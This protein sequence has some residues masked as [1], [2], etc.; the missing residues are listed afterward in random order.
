MI[1][2]GQICGP[3]Y[4]PK[5]MSAHDDCS[6]DYDPNECLTCNDFRE[7]EKDDE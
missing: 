5:W 2:I 7:Y 6:C 4:E 1:D 3:S